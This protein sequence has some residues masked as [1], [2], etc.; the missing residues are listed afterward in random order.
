MRQSHQLG[1]RLLRVFLPL[2]G[3][4]TLNFLYLCY[5]LIYIVKN[6]G[7]LMDETQS[8]LDYNLLLQDALTY[9][10]KEINK[11]ICY[12]ENSLYYHPS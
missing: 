3:S 6:G 4:K 7:D 12:L 10:E 11:E 9:Y 8:K 2:P 1:T 5:N